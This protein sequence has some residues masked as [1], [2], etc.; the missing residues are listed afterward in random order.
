[1]A[2]DLGRLPDRFPPLTCSFVVGEDFFLLRVDAQDRITGGDELG[3]SV[4]DEPE[5]PVAGRDAALPPGSCGSTAGRTPAGAAAGPP[6]SVRRDAL[7]RSIGRSG[8]RW[9]ASPAAAGT[10][11]HRESPGRS[12][13]SWRAAAPDRD[14]W[15]LGAHPLPAGHGHCCHSG[16]DLSESSGERAATGQVP[17]RRRRSRRG[18]PRRPTPRRPA[19]AGAH[20]ARATTC[21][22]QR[23]R[24]GKGPCRDSHMPR[25][26]VHLVVGPLLSLSSPRR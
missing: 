8:V 15:F 14:R 11:D 6:S 13:P 25:S 21:A 22:E 24:P 3:G 18:R 9:R 26:T 1:V 12:T 7:V 5:L 20:P 17:G 19:A 16:V 10:P 2:V 23:H 4:V